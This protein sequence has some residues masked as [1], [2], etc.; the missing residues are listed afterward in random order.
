[1]RWSVFALV[2]ATAAFA[3]EPETAPL[4]IEKFLGVTRYEIAR[5]DNFFQRGCVGTT[6]VYTRSANGEIAVR[7]RCRKGQLDGSE[8][9][10]SGKAWVPDAKVPGKWKIQFFWPF[11]A[12]LWLLDVAPDYSWALL[13]NAKKSS[14]WVLSVTTTMDEALYETLAGK[15]KVRGYDPTRL[16]KVLQVKPT[17]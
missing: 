6:S 4:D 5:Y 17:P 15:L 8:S 2:L 14:C 9:V 12:D 7:N 11:T 13:G 16:I 3:D 1:M 10:V